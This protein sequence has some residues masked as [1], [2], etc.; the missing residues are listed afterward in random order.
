MRLPGGLR[1]DGDGSGVFVGLPGNLSG[2]DPDPHDVPG[3]TWLVGPTSHHLTFGRRG[4]AS[5]VTPLHGRRA[6]RL[7]VTPVSSRYRFGETMTALGTPQRVTMTTCRRARAS[8]RSNCRRTSVAVTTTVNIRASRRRGWGSG[9]PTRFRDFVMTADL[10]RLR[11]AT[12]A[13][14]P[15]FLHCQGCFRATAR[16]RSPSPSASS[17]EDQD[18]P[19]FI[20][21]P[22]R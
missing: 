1:G 19:T 2:V 3:E 10:S 16:P 20:S 4:A 9:E 14:V 17:P 6:E 15:W 11:L 8:T 7:R 12:C 18:P 5:R 21:T 22:H 13:S